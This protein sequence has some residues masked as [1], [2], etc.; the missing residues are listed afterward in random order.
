MN[1][2]EFVAALAAGGAVVT[3]AKNGKLRIGCQTNAWKIDVPE[4]RNLLPVL[5]EIKKLGF[6]GFETGYR[7]VQGQFENLKEA[8]ELLRGTGLRF[9]GCHI[10]QF[11]YDPKT[12]I[13]AWELIERVA[14]GSSQLGAERLIVSGAPVGTDPERLRWKVGGLGRAGRLCRDLQMT[15]LLYH[16]H[17]PE[18]DNDA[19]EL[20]ALMRDTDPDTV[21]FLVDC[22]HALRRKADVAAFFLKNH[23]RIEGLHL[24]DF[25]GDAQVPLGQGSFDYA[26]L[27]A[28]V[29]KTGWQ[30]WVLNEEERES[31]E[32]P[33]ASA[34]EPARA[35]IRKLFGA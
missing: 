31:G 19:A 17:G 13:P 10:F 22:G 35:H 7:N 20:N 29:K 33:G 6:E 15:R 28:A 2:R 25:K 26:P 14:K 3:N 11:D 23:K 32:K 5:E 30:G 18:F 8:R 1:R 21:R 12:N 34:V 24:R 4:F 9:F 16:N 27:A